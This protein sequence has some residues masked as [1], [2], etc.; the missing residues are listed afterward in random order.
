MTEEVW[1]LWG[2][3]RPTMNTAQQRKVLD[4]VK[5]RSDAGLQVCPYSR[6]TKKKLLCKIN[7][8]RCFWDGDYPDCDVFCEWWLEAEESGLEELSPIS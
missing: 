2:D 1:K 4:Y 7:S 8:G 3:S 5:E 6:E